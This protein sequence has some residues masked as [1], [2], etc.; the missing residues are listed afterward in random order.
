MSQTCE[1]KAEECVIMHLKTL[2]Y[3]K[4][5]HPLQHSVLKI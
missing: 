4:F 2:R 5:F 3:K 1:E